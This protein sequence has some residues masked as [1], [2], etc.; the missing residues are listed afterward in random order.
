MAGVYGL[1]ESERALASL[2][3]ERYGRERGGAELHGFIENL[4][5]VKL[6]FNVAEQTRREDYPGFPGSS[7]ACL[8]T[9]ATSYPALV[10]AVINPF[11]MIH[12]IRVSSQ[13]LMGSD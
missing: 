4:K 5:N 10:T 11:L 3:S 9:I 1:T 13:R 7:A 2:F 12:L 6:P 8:P